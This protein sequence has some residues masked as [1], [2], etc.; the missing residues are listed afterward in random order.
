MP[1]LLVPLLVMAFLFYNLS[2]FPK[3]YKFLKNIENGGCI[4]LNGKGNMVRRGIGR[5]AVYLLAVDIIN[6]DGTKKTYESD[7]FKGK[8]QSQAATILGHVLIFREKISKDF[9]DK[10]LAEDFTVYVDIKNPKNYFVDISPL[11][12]AAEQK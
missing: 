12:I 1:L 2:K 7:Y 8:L 4:I 11:Y 10:V 9:F 5:D 6:P 3:F